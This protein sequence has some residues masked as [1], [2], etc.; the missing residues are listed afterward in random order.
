VFESLAKNTA[1]CNFSVH[2]DD[3]KSGGY[4]WARLCESREFVHA[5]CSKLLRHL[6]LRNDREHLSE[7]GCTATNG[8]DLESVWKILVNLPLFRQAMVQTINRMVGA[9]RSHELRQLCFAAACE[10][11]QLVEQLAQLRREDRNC[12]RHQTGLSAAFASQ[13]PSELA[14]CYCLAMVGDRKYYRSP[15]AV[16]DHVTQIMHRVGISL[17]SAANSTLWKLA[18]RMFV[19]VGRA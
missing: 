1:S 3:R 13:L 8:S 6:R 5:T 10:D 11:T 17:S 7:L 9:N 15:A 19:L 18:A 12:R 14:F 4:G 2:L 16:A